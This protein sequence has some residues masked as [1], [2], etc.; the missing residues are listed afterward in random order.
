MRKVLFLTIF[1]LMGLAGCSSSSDT[2]PCNQQITQKDCDATSQDSTTCTWD[3]NSCF[4]RTTASDCS[5]FDEADCNT[6][7][8]KDG[9]CYWTGSACAVA[10]A[11]TNLGS[12]DTCKLGDFSGTKC[13]W[14]PSASACAANLPALCTFNSQ[15]SSFASNACCAGSVNNC[16]TT[17]ASC[18]AP[19]KKTCTPKSSFSCTL[20]T[21][22]IYCC[23]GTATGCTATNSNCKFVATAGSCA[24]AS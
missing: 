23:S 16:T 13:A 15:A 17:D 12:E 7:S 1:G 11:C 24:D 18:N 8:G 9:Q 5:S 14:T 21:T 10:T 6:T 22:K 20:D 19:V 3:G 2:K 4:L